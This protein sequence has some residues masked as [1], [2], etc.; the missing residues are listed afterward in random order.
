MP[1]ISFY[2]GVVY[3]ADGR[4]RFAWCRDNGVK[5]MPVSVDTP[6]EAETIRKFFGSKSRTCRVPRCAP[7]S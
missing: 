1:H 3:F 6:G 4:H 2:E 7:A 5:A